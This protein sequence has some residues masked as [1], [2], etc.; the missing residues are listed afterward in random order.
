[1]APA[2]WVM[3]RGVKIIYIFNKYINFKKC[4]LKITKRKK[5]KKSEVICEIGIEGMEGGLRNRWGP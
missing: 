5:K 2:R 1:M 4:D 3:S